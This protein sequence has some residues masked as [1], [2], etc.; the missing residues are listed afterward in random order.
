MSIEDTV[1]DAINALAER[2]RDDVFNSHCLRILDDKFIFKFEYA[3]KIEKNRVV[4]TVKHLKSAFKKFRGKSSSSIIEIKNI[5]SE[6]AKDRGLITISISDVYSSFLG[7]QNL[8]YLKDI[9][10]YKLYE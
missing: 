8:D 9:I 4:K 2:N 3:S 10:F 6:I 5:Q 7:K 1:T